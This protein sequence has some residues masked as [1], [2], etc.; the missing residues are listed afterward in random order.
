MEKLKFRISMFGNAKLLNS[1]GRKKENQEFQ[2][3]EK[4]KSRFPKFGESKIQN[5]SF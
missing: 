5:S 2:C 1:N 4:P 3:L